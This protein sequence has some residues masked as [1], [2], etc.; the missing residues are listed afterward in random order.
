MVKSARTGAFFHI[1]E[2]FV[3]QSIFNKVFIGLNLEM[4]INMKILVILETI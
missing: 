4:E 3:A 2:S 1:F